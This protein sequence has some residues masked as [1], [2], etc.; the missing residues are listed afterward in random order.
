MDEQQKPL[1]EPPLITSSLWE[2]T[3]RQFTKAV[4]VLTSL[5]GM[6]LSAFEAFHVTS[7]GAKTAAVQP[8]SSQ[9]GATCGELVNLQG[10]IGFMWPSPMSSTNP[11]EA[12][13]QTA[14]LIDSA[15]QVGDGLKTSPAYEAYS[16]AVTELY[17]EYLQTPFKVESGSILSDPVSLFKNGMADIHQ[18]FGVAGAEA[19]HP[20][21]IKD[22]GQH[23]MHFSTM[24]AH[25]WRETLFAEFKDTFAKAGMPLNREQLKELEQ[26]E[27]EHV[28]KLNQP[29]RYVPTDLPYDRHAD[30]AVGLGL[31]PEKE[32][33]LLAQARLNASAPSKTT[34][35]L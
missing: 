17:H 33:S 24:D 9:E 22:F 32:R 25:H 15:I 28:A 27:R 18:R 35:T 19:V 31:M 21:L 16:R 1:Q 8:F 5:V 13:K 7:S 29:A 34:Q 20:M 12:W 14:G 6:P 30:A 11:V 4:A 3:R 26:F 23:F 2:L 10:Q